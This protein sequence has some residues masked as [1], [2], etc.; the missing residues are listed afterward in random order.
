LH[1]LDS[2]AD[3][4]VDFTQATVLFDLAPAPDCTFG[5]FEVSCPSVPRTV[6]TISFSYGV[7]GGAAVSELVAEMD[8]DVCAAKYPPCQG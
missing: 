8:D 6:S 7:R 1:I 2:S 4:G 5:Q 3:E